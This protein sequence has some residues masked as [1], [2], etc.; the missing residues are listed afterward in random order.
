M[1][2]KEL[3]RAATEPAQCEQVR[4]IKRS[5]VLTQFIVETI[6]VQVELTDAELALYGEFELAEIVNDL[7]TERD[8]TQTI[9]SSQVEVFES[10]TTLT[11]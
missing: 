6:V 10:G 7:A 5:I 8:I 4:P 9:E 2:L 3:I 1:D 11:L